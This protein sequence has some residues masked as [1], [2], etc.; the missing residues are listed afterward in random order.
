M[1]NVLI[2]S[3][4]MWWLTGLNT[5]ATQMCSFIHSDAPPTLH[6]RIHQLPTSLISLL[7]LPDYLHNVYVCSF[8]CSLRSHS[9]MHVTW[10]AWYGAVQDCHCTLPPNWRQK[11][12][13]PVTNR[14]APLHRVWDEGTADRVP[15]VAL[16]G[17]NWVQV[18]GQWRFCLSTPPRRIKKHL[19]LQTSEV[20]LPF[21]KLQSLPSQEP[22]EEDSWG[23]MSIE[24]YI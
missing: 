10:A 17:C 11:Q 8:I 22:S 19:Q 15:A 20:K 24:T 14:G 6:L 3:F 23:S 16:A 21:F 7:F 2:V 18:F 9:G 12:N 13:L 1:T 4:T 5:V